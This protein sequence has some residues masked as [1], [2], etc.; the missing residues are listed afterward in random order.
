MFVKFNKGEYQDLEI[1][2]NFSDY[3]STLLTELNEILYLKNVEFYIPTILK[4]YKYSKNSKEN[5]KYFYLFYEILPKDSLSIVGKLPF[6]NFKEQIMNYPVLYPSNFYFGYLLYEISD[7]NEYFDRLIDVEYSENIDKQVELKSFLINKD[8]FVKD[9]IYFDNFQIDFDYYIK[10][11]NKELSKPTFML[12]S[13]KLIPQVY[14][15]INDIGYVIIDDIIIQTFTKKDI[16]PKFNNLIQFNVNLYTDFDDLNNLSYTFL[17]VWNLIYSNYDL[18]KQSEYQKI[19]YN[20]MN[21][22][23]MERMNEFKIFIFLNKYNVYDLYVNLSEYFDKYIVFDTIIGLI[24]KYLLYNVDSDILFDLLYNLSYKDILKIILEYLISNFLLNFESLLDERI[25]QNLAIFLSSIDLDILLILFGNQFFDFFKRLIDLQISLGYDIIKIQNQIQSLIISDDDFYNQLQNIIDYVKNNKINTKLFEIDFKLKDNLNDLFEELKKIFP[26]FNLIDLDVLNDDIKVLLV[27]LLQTYLKDI[28]NIKYEDLIEEFSSQSFVYYKNTYQNQLFNK[29]SSNQF[30]IVEMNIGQTTF[31]KINNEQFWF[32]STKNKI[33]F[34]ILNSNLDNEENLHSLLENSDLI[35]LLNSLSIK[36][37]QFLDIF[38]NVETIRKKKFFKF[39]D[40]F[41]NS[42]SLKK[43]QYKLVPVSETN[44]SEEKLDNY[45][46]TVS[47]S[48]DIVNNLSEIILVEI[49]KEKVY[50]KKDTIIELI[51]E[52]GTNSYKINEENIKNIIKMDNYY[53]INDIILDNSEIIN[54]INCIDEIVLE[55]E[56][57][58]IKID[59][60]TNNSPIIDNNNYLLY[61]DEKKNLSGIFEKIPLSNPF[62]NIYLQQNF[63]D[64]KIPYK[65]SNISSITLDNINDILNNSIQNILNNMCIKDI[66][67]TLD[68]FQQN[69]P[70]SNETIIKIIN[71]EIPISQDLLKQIENLL[72]D[73][74]FDQTNNISTDLFLQKISDLLSKASEIDEIKEQLKSLNYNDDEILNQLIKYISAIDKIVEIQDKTKL[75]INRVDK[76]VLEIIVNS[77]KGCLS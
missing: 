29:S 15:T 6:M 56:N 58:I 9:S 25:L 12:N 73:K 28:T 47:L 41:V 10:F 45:L 66:S 37:L 49:Y 50:D 52:N 68:N 53:V 57:K 48:N 42:E 26:F 20:I 69:Y 61:Y 75:D 65:I 35:E 4:Y 7:F 55:Y 1:M 19:F 54:T 17:P 40:M 39:V 63:Y 70:I 21:K 11:I 34:S 32:V 8:I 77:S 76:N 62:K 31:K 72:K 30:T 43:Q 46:S 13:Y 2:N 24:S 60:S 64:I 44:L 51:V 38:M 23:I 16:N 3:I 27:L 74:L 14:D 36:S 5:N 59:L 22:I 18:S 67:K 71:N 33:P